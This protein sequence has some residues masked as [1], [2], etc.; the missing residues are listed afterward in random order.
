MNILEERGEIGQSMQ[1]LQKGFFFFLEFLS[2]LIFL[3][4]ILKDTVRIIV[5][6]VIFISLFISNLLIKY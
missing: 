1:V 3:A 2:A 4:S 5:I 6:H